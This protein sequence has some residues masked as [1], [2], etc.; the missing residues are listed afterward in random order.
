MLKLWVIY[1]LQSLGRS[2]TPTQVE[3]LNDPLGEEK[4][5]TGKNKLTIDM[6][7]GNQTIPI[8]SEYDIDYEKF[9]D[10]RL[11]I[12]KIWDL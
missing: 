1:T 10:H 4:L 3:T 8:K 5:G 2:D 11:V 7:L 6:C 12:L 9:K